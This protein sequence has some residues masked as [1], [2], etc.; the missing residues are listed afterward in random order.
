MYDAGKLTPSSLK[1]HR[2]RKFEAYIDLRERRFLEDKTGL[3]CVVLTS[4]SLHFAEL[5]GYDM[6]QGGV[7]KASPGWISS[8]LERSG[9]TG[10]LVHGEAMDMSEE[11]RIEI[12]KPW[13]IKFHALIEKYS[14]KVSTLYNGDQTGLFYQKLPNRI[15]VSKC[16]AKKYNGVKA[17]KDK[18]RCIV[19]VCTSADGDKV[20]LS[21]IGNA[22]TPMCFR[23]CP[24]SK[25]PC[26]YMNQHNV[27][28]DRRITLWWLKTVFLAES[29]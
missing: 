18:T 14:I 2:T 26:A 16:N 28:F 17:M 9:K 15:Y 11:V 6:G 21:V 19:M 27:W 13:L 29:C 5:L 3:S 24:G 10:K 4:K 8:V 7:F 25:P 12:M 20:S 1:R 22:K 23:L